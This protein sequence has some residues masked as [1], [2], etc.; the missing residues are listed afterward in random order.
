MEKTYLRCVWLQDPFDEK[1]F[2]VIKKMV[3]IVATEGPHKL[4]PKSR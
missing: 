3:I 4:P 2:L 1:L